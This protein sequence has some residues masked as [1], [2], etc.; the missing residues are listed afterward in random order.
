MQ[1][2][3][4][5]A[6]IVLLVHFGIVLFILGGLF[7][8]VVGNLR[9]WQWVNNFWFRVVHLVAIGVV[10]LQSWLG[11]LCPLTMLESWLREK[12]GYSGYG[13]SFIEHWVQSLLYYEGP[14]WV[15]A[16]SYTLFGLVVVFVW[17]RFPPHSM[18]SK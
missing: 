18:G 2:Y 4:A 9:H 6:D 13:K 15:F 16:V 12:A 8:I 11:E 1:P 3:K 14:F 5:L 10:V 17:W 7:I